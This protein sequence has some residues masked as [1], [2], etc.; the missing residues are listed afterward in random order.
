MLGGMSQK[1]GRYDVDEDMC[2]IIGGLWPWYCVALRV[3]FGL[4]LSMYVVLGRAG[5]LRY[6]HRAQSF[7]LRYKY[8][9]QSFL[10]RIASLIG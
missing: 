3:A 2:N 6:K 9:A 4:A 5:G 7:L 1:E 10:L 8:R